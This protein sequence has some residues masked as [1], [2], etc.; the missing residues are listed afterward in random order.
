VVCGL[1]PLAALIGFAVWGVVL[2]I[3]R[4]ISVASM[5]GAVVTAALL[6]SLFRDVPHTLFGLLVALFVLL[7]H[8][9]NVSRL[10]AGTEPKVRQGK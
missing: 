9:P 4:F 10:R 1:S 6:I 3:T 2:G 5:V 7:K 8:R